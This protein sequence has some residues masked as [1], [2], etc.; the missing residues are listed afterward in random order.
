MKLLFTH[1][2]VQ[3]RKF[4]TTSKT[5]PRETNIIWECLGINGHLE[6]VAADKNT[7]FKMAIVFFHTHICSCECL[8]LGGYHN[9]IEKTW[10]A[11]DMMNWVSTNWMSHPN[12]GILEVLSF[13]PE[14][15]LLPKLVIWIESNHKITKWINSPGII[16][17]ILR[18]L[19]V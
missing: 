1:R 13:Q 8:V 12:P 5:L 14:Q 3:W 2:V 19:Q 9:T 18:K 15:Y 10:W 4:C 6:I 17:T 11:A 16:N 7:D